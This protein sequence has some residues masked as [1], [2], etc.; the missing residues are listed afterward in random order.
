M[1]N[2][3]YISIVENIED[4]KRI[5]CLLQR[6][7]KMFFGVLV[8]RQDEK[9]KYVCVYIGLDRTQYDIIFKQRN[10]IEELPGYFI[11]VSND[12]IDVKQITAD[13]LMIQK[14]THYIGFVKPPASEMT[15]TL[16][17]FADSVYNRLEPADESA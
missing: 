1:K 7:E 3:K 13:K 9:E 2:S 15:A 12:T 17:A 10:F 14:P 6:G 8:Q 16:L 4:R 11:G 5:V